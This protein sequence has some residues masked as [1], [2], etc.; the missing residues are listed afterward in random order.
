MEKLIYLSFRFH[1]LLF[2]LGK[3]F[4]H[5]YYFTKAFFLKLSGLKSAVTQLDRC[6]LSLRIGRYTALNLT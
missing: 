1:D 5:L 3:N 6:P 4:I 2:R